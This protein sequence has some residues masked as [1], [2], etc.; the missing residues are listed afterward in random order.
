MCRKKLKKASKNAHFLRKF[1]SYT[2]LD[3]TEEQKER[4]GTMEENGTSEEEIRDTLQ[5][6]GEKGKLYSVVGEF[7]PETYF[8]QP[9]VKENIERSKENFSNELDDIVWGR[10]N[11]KRKPTVLFKPTK[12]WTMVGLPDRRISFDQSKIC[13]IIKEHGLTIDDLKALPEKLANPEYI[14]ESATDDSAYV[15]VLDRNNEPFVAVVKPVGDGLKVTNIIKSAYNKHQGFVNQEIKAGRML[16]DKQNP[17][18]VRRHRALIAQVFGSSD[19]GNITQENENVKL[20]SRVGYNQGAYTP[21]S[22]IIELA[23]EHT[24]DTFMHEVSH[25]FFINYF[26]AIERIAD[27]NSDYVKQAQYLG[28]KMLYFLFFYVMKVRLV[29]EYQVTFCDKCLKISVLMPWG[30]S[31]ALTT[32][33]QVINIKIRIEV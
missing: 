22:R 13:R 2:Y 24:P 8:E 18:S 9:E 6:M 23:R 19:N 25:N 33:L 17:M 20:F 31:H 29:I 10:S 15:G 30:N 5:E 28:K 32:E 14:F 1:C 12:I 21:I 26:D 27:K 16:Y 7:N 3:N 11:P 4:I